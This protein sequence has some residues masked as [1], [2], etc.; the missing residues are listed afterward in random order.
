MEYSHPFHSLE[1]EKGPMSFNFGHTHP[2]IVVTKFP[3][4]PPPPWGHPGIDLEDLKSVTD[5]GGP[6][7]QNSSLFLGTPKRQTEDKNV[8]RMHANVVF[9][10]QSSP[11]PLWNPGCALGSWRSN[12]FV[13]QILVECYNHTSDQLENVTCN[14]TKIKK[15]VGI[16]LNRYSLMCSYLL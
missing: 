3:P 14:S 6:G 12:I 4:P 8:V 10:M 2:G 13:V 7:D 5:P 1:L 9:I 15:I 11:H 16:K